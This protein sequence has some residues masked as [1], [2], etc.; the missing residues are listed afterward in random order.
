MGKGNYLGEFEQLVL[1]ALIRLEDNAY[2]M[3]IRQT[4]QER[5]RRAVAIGQVY[6]ALERLELKGFLGSHTS[7]PEPIRGGRSKKL[8]R[9]TPEGTAALSASRQMMDRMADGLDLADGRIA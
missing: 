8:Y 1:L 4:I 7:G 9:L 5:T 3:T 6:S 2:G